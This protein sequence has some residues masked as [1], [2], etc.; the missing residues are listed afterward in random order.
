LS[1]APDSAPLPPCVWCGGGL[2][3]RET[4]SMIFRLSPDAIDLTS[5]E[6]GRTLDVNESFTRLYGYS[7]EEALGRT[8]LPGGLDLWAHPADR[9]RLVAG[10]RAQGEVLGFEATLR[11]KDGSLFTALISA[12]L[13]EIDGLPCNLAIIRDITARKRA[14]LAHR[15][16]ELQFQAT[17]RQLRRLNEDLEERIRQRTA[18]LEAANAELD[19][20]CYSVSHDLRAPLRGIDGFSQALQEDCADQLGEQGRHYLE[21]VRAGTQRM[22]LLID[23]LLKLS[24]VSRGALNRVPLDL[25]AMA[26][27]LVVDLRQRDPDRSVEVQVQDG[28]AALGDPGLVRVALGNLLDNAWKYTARAAQARIAFTRDPEAGRDD[29]FRVQDNGAGF[30]MRYADKLF[31]AFQRLHSAADFEGTGIGLAIVQ[32]IIRR[33]GGRVWAEGAEGAGATFHFTLPEHP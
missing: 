29:A 8:S 26:R 3:S 23:D 21:R 24:R 32:R 28:L 16:S 2:T 14:E 17:Q 11:K 15:E 27:A 10:L 18:L 12:S 31:T 25:T 1:G 5:L 13:L 4:F 30:D 19:A 9:E 7:R 22:G 20:F 33:H 6:D